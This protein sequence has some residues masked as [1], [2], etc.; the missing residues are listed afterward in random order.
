M[1]TLRGI[2]F[3]AGKNLDPGFFQLR[4]E[5]FGIV[6]TEMIGKRDHMHAIILACLTCHGTLIQL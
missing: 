4:S 5:V 3:K 6:K 2:C 1:Y